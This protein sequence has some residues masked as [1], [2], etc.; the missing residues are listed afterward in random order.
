LI[1]VN[2]LAIHGRGS[3]L[4][5]MPTPHRL[6]PTPSTSRIDPPRSILVE[7]VSPILNNTVKPLQPP[8]S[9]DLRATVPEPAPMPAKESKSS[10]AETSTGTSFTPRPLE[11]VV[12]QHILATIQHTRGN[13]NQAARLLRINIRTLRNK[14]ISYGRRAEEELEPSNNAAA[15][16]DGARGSH[17]SEN[18]GPHDP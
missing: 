5:L 18:L 12:R 14:L 13:R 6:V 17:R 3:P 15:R 16:V 8:A 7:P 10:A 4:R 2:H 11:A 9:L 1:E